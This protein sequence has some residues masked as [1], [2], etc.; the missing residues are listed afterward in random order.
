MPPKP[1][2]SPLEL[3]LARI[4]IDPFGCWYWTGH[5]DNKGYGRF[6]VNTN[7]QN[8]RAGETGIHNTLKTHCPQGHPYNRANTYVYHTQDGRALRQCRVCHAEGE[9][10]RRL[11]CALSKV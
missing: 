8:C 1:A 9:R 5:I 6:F 3:F 7:R 4:E 11:L 2:G 10:K